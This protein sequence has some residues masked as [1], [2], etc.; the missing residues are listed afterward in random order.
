MFDRSNEYYDPYEEF[1]MGMHYVYDWLN[2][3]GI[4]KH[5]IGLDM[6][7]DKIETVFK[8]TVEIPSD[9]NGGSFEPFFG[10][11]AGFGGMVD[12]FP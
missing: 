5:V 10:L 11:Q 9:P 2:T 12:L 1:G 6:Y 4:P 3:A 8:L 7:V